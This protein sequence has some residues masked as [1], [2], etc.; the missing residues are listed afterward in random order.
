MNSRIFLT[1]LH[2][3]LF[4][5]SKAKS[6]DNSSRHEEMVCVIFWHSFHISHTSWFSK[7]PR[8][9]STAMKRFKSSNVTCPL[10]VGAASL[11]DWNDT[12]TSIFYMC[13]ITISGCL[14]NGIF[15]SHCYV[16]RMQWN[17]KSPNTNWGIEKPLYW[18]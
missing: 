7:Q 18:L 13:V 16:S 5:R 6:A 4:N 1:L 10:S 12:A 15:K 3:R 8:S 2:R 9:L 11:P 14:I 17:P